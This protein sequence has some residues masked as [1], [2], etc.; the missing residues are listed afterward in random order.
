[1]KTKHLF[2]ALLLSIMLV[3]PAVN[4]EAVKVVINDV[5]PQ[6]VEP[7]NDLT[8]RVTYSNV[9]KDFIRNISSS[10]DLRYPFSLKTSTESYE[11]GLELCAYCSR[12]NTFFI[13]I[14]SAARSGTYPIFI[15]TREL[16]SES[17]RTISATVRGKP[18]FAL[19]SDVL[20]NITPSNV[21]DMKLLLTNIGTGV[22]NQIKVT[23]KSSDFISLG[24]SVII[25]ETVEPGNSTYVTFQMSPN[26]NLKAGAYSL[27]FEISYNDESGVTYNTTQ[28]IGTR[29][30]N[31]GL[32]NI[33]SMKVTSST[34]KPI[35]GQPVTIIVRLE[36]IGHGNANYIESQISC[37]GQ[38]VKAFL[39]QLKKDEDAPAVFEITLP[40][41]GIYNCNLV[42]N[43]ADDLG[44][45]TITNN[46]DIT[47]GRAEIPPAAIVVII[48]IIIGAAYYLRKR[49]SRKKGG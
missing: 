35:A 20:S 9:D 25:I 40:S 44:K 7:G 17:V 22:A 45:H 32:L 43:Y 15:R 18:N 29:V 10:I 24:S 30:V 31:E 38:T 21:F 4:A 39:G 28:N 23:S 19:S 37:D 49:H 46:F 13:H 1:M 36:N 11:N 16:D 3:L 27:P 8:L 42:T 26:D 34:G 6:P 5:T 33:E 47:L 41:G 14:D 12:T 2:I 48:I